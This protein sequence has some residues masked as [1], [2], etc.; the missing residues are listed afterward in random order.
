MLS[1]GWADWILDIWS[2]QGCGGA[3]RLRRGSDF[4]KIQILKRNLRSL[5][6][7]FRDLLELRICS[8]KPKTS[9]EVHCAPFFS[10][11]QL[12]IILSAIFRIQ[13]L[14]KFGFS[15]ASSREA[16]GRWMLKQSSPAPAAWFFF[17]FLA[18]SL[19]KKLVFYHQKLNRTH[20]RA[21]N[22]IVSSEM[23]VSV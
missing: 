5:A 22:A 11:H 4:G 18:E 9:A 12:S 19:S 10:S 7:S 16:A 3:P 8:S 23:V 1:F 15:V 17:F 13:Q 14:E 21:E 2:Q 20:S 6:S